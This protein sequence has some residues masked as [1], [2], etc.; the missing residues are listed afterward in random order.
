[1]RWNRNPVWR[2]AE[3]AIRSTLMFVLFALFATHCRP[4]WAASNVWTRLQLGRANLTAV[5]N[6]RQNPNTVYAL[7]NG[8]LPSEPTLVFKTTDGGENWIALST[9]PSQGLSTIEINPKTP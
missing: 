2:R 1:M 6:D 5:A 4:V 9:M 3:S 8:A 7:N